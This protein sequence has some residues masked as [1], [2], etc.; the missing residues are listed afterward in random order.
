LPEA[1]EGIHAIENEGLA[2]DKTGCHVRVT[3]ETGVAA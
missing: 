2:T 3:A 1:V